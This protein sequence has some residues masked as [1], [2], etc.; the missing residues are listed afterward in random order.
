MESFEDKIFDF[1]RKKAIREQRN[2]N[3]YKT[4]E[5]FYHIQADEFE[6]VDVPIKTFRVSDF[7]EDEIK[8]HFEQIENYKSL[9]EGDR[10]LIGENIDEI[11]RIST[12]QIV[13]KS[14]RKFRRSDGDGWGDETHKIEKKIKE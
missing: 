7:S 10:V 11:V 5:G 12:R 9:K 4:S 6:N 13:T 3:V 1:A 8:K 2:I 14:G